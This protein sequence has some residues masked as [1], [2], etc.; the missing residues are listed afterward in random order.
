VQIS[1]NDLYTNHAGHQQHDQVI[2]ADQHDRSINHDNHN[3]D[4]H[5]MLMILDGERYYKIISDI[6]NKTSY[7]WVNSY[8]IILTPC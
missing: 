2:Q 4:N 5:P 3:D 7:L 6:S 1:F 8:L